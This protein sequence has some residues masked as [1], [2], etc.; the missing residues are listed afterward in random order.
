MCRVVYTKE[1]VVNYYKRVKIM[2]GQFVRVGD[3]STTGG[4]VLSGSSSQLM[5]GKLIARVGDEVSCPLCGNVGLIAEGNESILIDGKAA[6]VD[7]SLVV[8]DCPLGSHRVLATVI[9]SAPTP[10]LQMEKR[11]LFSGS[12]KSL[13]S[14][15]ASNRLD[16]PFSLSLKLDGYANKYAYR[17][18]QI[19]MENGQVFH[20]VTDDLAVTENIV[21]YGE[22]R[23]VK[24][25]VTHEMPALGG[26]FKKKMLCVYQCDLSEVLTKKQISEPVLLQEDDGVHALCADQ[27]AVVNKSLR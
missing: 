16:E 12:K 22:R 2:I 25:E 10:I 9:H 5:D 15:I 26:L 14:P 7:G 27:I 18:Y 24:I 3:S 11:T 6:A 13:K 20:G 8:C 1:K 17:A 19:T 4:L 21:T 23:I